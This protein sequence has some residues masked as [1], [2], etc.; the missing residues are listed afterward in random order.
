MTPAPSS[1]GSVAIPP[2]ETNE[3]T[4]TAGID[5]TSDPSS[6]NRLKL[7]NKS[8]R[9][10]VKT[11][12]APSSGAAAVRWRSLNVDTSSDLDGGTVQPAPKRLDRRVYS[13]KYYSKALPLKGNAQSQSREKNYNFTF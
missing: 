10:T 11:I 12:L 6:L 2:Q 1:F 4:D 5:G 7:L 9:K 8:Q 3:V 13:A